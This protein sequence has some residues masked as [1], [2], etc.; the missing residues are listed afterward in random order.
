MSRSRIA[1]VIAAVAVVVL[2]AATAAYFVGQSTRMSDG[3]V[4]DRVA[5]AVA[6]RGD[7][8]EQE[9]EEALDSQ[10]ARY[11]ERIAVV[12]K[13]SRDRGYKIG[14]KSGYAEGNEDGYS[15]GSSVGFSSGHS[16]GKEEGIEEASDELLCSDD[17]DVDLPPCVFYGGY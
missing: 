14:K 3:A 13:V 4:V 6:E 2:T 9:Q 12:R 7:K 11:R 8:A 17:S 5:L 16:E 10:G 1:G 15:A